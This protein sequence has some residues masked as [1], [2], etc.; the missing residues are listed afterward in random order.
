M[1]SPDTP[2][3]A[4]FVAAFKRGIEREVAAMR[5]SSE[6]FEL[7]LA[8]GEQLDARRYAFELAEASDRLVPG[9]ECALR[10][11]R[12]E[13]RVTVE[14]CEDLRLTV[15]SE[16]PID[17]AGRPLVLVIAPWFLY[18]RLVGALDELDAD[19]HPVSLALALFGKR[20]PRRAASALRC[21]HTALNLSQRAAVQLCSDSELAFL[22]GPPGTGKTAA[23]THVVEELLAQDRRILL[24]S[25]TNAAIDQVLAKLAARPWFAAAVA[26][27]ALVRLGRSDE[28]TF[29]AELAD[30]AGRMQGEHRGAID[31]RRAR[32]AEAELL[33]QRGDRLLAELAAAAVPQQSLFAAP[34]AGL[35]PAALASVFPPGLAD[36]VARLPP[37]DQSAALR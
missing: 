7:P 3:L 6:T 35:R 25:T 18:D 24:A 9:G 10:T 20:P 33:L 23:L 22:W 36:A 27:G 13:Q 8:G 37:P 14:R 1:S 15:T 2:L 29:G 12:G 4:R 34:A 16:A 21:D 28:D 26:A 17:L 30:V 11:P 32:I 31:R 19:R 5:T